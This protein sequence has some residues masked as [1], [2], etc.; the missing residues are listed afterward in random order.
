MV[1][2]QDLANLKKLA[3]AARQLDGQLGPSYT[4]E[5]RFYAQARRKVPV[6]VDELE[7]ALALLEGVKAELD[8]ARRAQRG[9]TP[10]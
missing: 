4:N 3:L 5:A 7:A 9:G 1:V 2:N 10:T 6:L 8:R